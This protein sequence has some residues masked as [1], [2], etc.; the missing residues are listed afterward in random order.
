M[1]LTTTM[2]FLTIICIICIIIST[3]IIVPWMSIVSANKIFCL[4]YNSL[5]RGLMY[6][7]TCMS[8]FSLQLYYIYL[9]SISSWKVLLAHL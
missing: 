3:D 5:R 4:V 9:Y 8:L 1:V 7:T 2:Q 6:S